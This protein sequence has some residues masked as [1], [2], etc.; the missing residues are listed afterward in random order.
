[1]DYYKLKIFALLMLLLLLPLMVASSSLK[2]GTL[3]TNDFVNYW[4]A[5]RL[6]LA[7]INPYSPR[8]LFEIQRSVGWPFSIPEVTTVPPWSLFFVLPFG[9]F[10]FITGQLIWLTLH[11]M[12]VLCC[13]KQ[14]WVLY[15][16]PKEHYRIS[17]VLAFSFLPTPMALSA[18]QMVPLLLLGLTGFLFFEKKKAWICAGASLA[19]TLVK[20][21][22]AYLVW[23]AAFLWVIYQRRFEIILGSAIVI[24]TICLVPLIWNA[25][26]YSQYFH[27]WSIL[28]PLDFTYANRQPTT[29]RFL[30]YLFDVKSATIQFLPTALGVMWIL[31][32]WGRNSREWTWAD[33]M[34]LLLLV[35]ACTVPYGSLA[36]Q[37][38]LLPAL[39]QSA[40]NLQRN[41]SRAIRVLTI[42]FY[43]TI[44]AVAGTIH[45]FGRDE[46]WFV[47]FGPSLL[48]AYVLLMRKSRLA[49]GGG[50]ANR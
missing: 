34:P 11:S 48:L 15:G 27:T 23:I 28:G 12:I 3:A 20:P 9:L 22:V 35:S 45:V 46:F 32:E 39:M 42:V 38:V 41:N 36:D 10:D 19:I 31:I 8:E 14:L 26:I 43:G 25:G 1:M 29:G 6:E 47:W 4:A 17:W 49:L 21:H 50:A 7:G 37:I 16:G 33:K 5:G 2:G 18:R 24:L 44:T 30:E 13:A 40:I